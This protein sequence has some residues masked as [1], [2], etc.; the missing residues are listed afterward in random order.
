MRH[1]VGGFNGIIMVRM[2]IDYKEPIGFVG[3][4]NMGRP[5]A[6]NLTKV[7]HELVVYDAAGTASRAPKNTVAASSVAEV[8]AKTEAIFLSLP[9]VTASTGVAQ[10]IVDSD[11]RIARCVIDTSTIGVP[12]A[13]KATGQDLAEQAP[14]EL[15]G[16]QG[17]GL[18]AI[19]RV[20]A[21]VVPLEGDATL[22]TGNQTAVGDRHS[23]GV[24][25]PLG[26]PGR[27]RVVSDIVGGVRG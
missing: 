22:I 5:M 3:L 13:V 12:D 15:V 6:I 1:R 16:S 2:K 10:E 19:T 21:I 20:G 4:G 9:D 14:A 24:A 8:A 7:G 17:H 23:M 26:E 25:R 11:P 27:G 18:G